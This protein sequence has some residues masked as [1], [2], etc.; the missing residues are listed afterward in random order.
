MKPG[1]NQYLFLSIYRAGLSPS[2]RFRVEQYLPHLQ[3]Q[4]YA[5]C[6]YSFFS[7]GLSS[8]NF[9]QGGLLL[10]TAHLLWGFLRMCRGLLLARNCKAVIVQ[11][12]LCPIGPPVFEWLLTRLLRKP[13]VYDFDDAVWLRHTSGTLGRIIKCPWKTSRQISWAAQV[14]AGNAYLLDY[15]LR[16]NPRSHLLP[17]VLPHS[18]QC[19]TYPR[20]PLTL[21]WTGSYT[22]LPYLLELEPVLYR[23]QQHFKFNLLVICNANPGFKRLQYRYVPWLAAEEQ[24]QLLQIDIGLM[25]QPDTPWTRGKC[26][27]KLIQYMALGI[28]PIASYSALHAELLQNGQAGILCQNP[29]AW[30]HQ[31]QKL[32]QNPA[33]CEALGRAARQ[34]QQSHYSLEVHLPTFAKLLTCKSL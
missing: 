14:F 6:Q 17:T 33:A 26:G 19:I 23:L 16:Y 22:T 9:R 10:G 7:P 29:Q 15:A 21:G 20:N 18:R 31:L 5:I 32:L 3:Q 13:Y 34:W 2:Q 1:P 12:E 11:R 30:E 27:F 28:C 24:A 4:G 8:S 25:P